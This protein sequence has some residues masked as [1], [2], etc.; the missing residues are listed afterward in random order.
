MVFEVLDLQRQQLITAVAQTFTGLHVDIQQLAAVI[1]QKSVSEV[2]RE[3]D[4]T[5]TGQT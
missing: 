1:M 4:G 3:N 2:I 5:A